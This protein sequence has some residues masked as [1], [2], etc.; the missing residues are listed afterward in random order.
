ESCC[1]HHR[2]E[3]IAT[4]SENLAADLP[5]PPGLSPELVAPFPQRGRIEMQAMLLR[6]ADGSVQLVGDGGSSRA[7]L[8]DTGAGD[9]DGEGRALAALRPPGDRVVGGG[10]P[11]SDLAREDG[12]RVLDGLELRQCAA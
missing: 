9:A 12:K 7:R 1:R 10:L 11:G 5:G 4:G 2:P 3:R 6:I 8:A